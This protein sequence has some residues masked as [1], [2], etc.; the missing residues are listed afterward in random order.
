MLL[1]R[2][3]NSSKGSH[4][5]RMY[6]FDSWK[7]SSRLLG[8]KNEYATVSEKSLSDLSAS[9]GGCLTLI[10]YYISSIAS[11]L[12]SG[13]QSPS[14]S[15]FSGKTGTGIMSVLLPLR[16]EPYASD[17]TVFNVVGQNTE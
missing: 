13:S 8:S 17:A 16:D 6:S 2:R 1:A 14:R 10:L 4:K 15:T 11:T 12:F 3:S 9:Y 5:G 7:A